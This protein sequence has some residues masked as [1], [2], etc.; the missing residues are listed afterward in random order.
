MNASTVGSA[1]LG[2][3]VFFFLTRIGL[4]LIDQTMAVIPSLVAPFG[5]AP[6][7]SL[8]LPLSFVAVELPEGRKYYSMGSDILVQWVRMLGYQ[9]L[10][11]GIEPSP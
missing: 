1:F 10:K 5:S 3:K 8:G 2:L 4:Y 6:L 11:S 9:V 7:T